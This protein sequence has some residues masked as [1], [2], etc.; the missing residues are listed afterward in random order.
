MLRNI[1]LWLMFLTTVLPAGAQTI[2]LGFNEGITYQ[3]NSESVKASYEL[4]AADLEKVLG[5]RV[6]IEAV[7]NYP[8]LMV[9]L[10]S[11]R[12]D[13]AFV[14]PTH[15]SIAALR[16]KAYV[17]AATSKAHIGYRTA[18]LSPKGAT[19]K[20]VEDFAKCFVDGT[21]GYVQKGIGSPD[22]ESITAHAV[23]ATLRDVAAI[24]KSKPYSVKY[25][26]FQDSIPKM[27]DYG[28]VDVAATSSQSTISEWTK[29]GG[30]VLFYT[31]AMPIK[32]LL[33]SSRFDQNAS[34]KIAGYFIGLS[35]TPEGRQRLER[36]GLPQGF[37]TLDASELTSL[38]TWLGI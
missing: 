3:S 28:F 21:L 26:K 32:N 15:I 13:I 2:T 34:A 36:I 27:I 29:K 8:A 25:T 37:I 18:F 4:I 12:F 14:H 16:S 5:K 38:G 24:N 23:R 22:A 20:S 33:L 30:A 31:R 6:V 17:L 9:G 35:S 19:A 7:S 10:E 1:S 11:S